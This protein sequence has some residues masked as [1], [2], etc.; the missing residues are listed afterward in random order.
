MSYIFYDDIE[1]YEGT[2]SAGGDETIT[3]S[4]FP[5]ACGIEIVND[6]TTDIE[7]EYDGR[8]YTAGTVKAGE[9]HFEPMVFKFVKLTNTSGSVAA[10]YRVRIGTQTI[11]RR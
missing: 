1:G 11:A 9:S 7:Y 8:P 6:G 5:V 4:N 10:S 3:V 2:I